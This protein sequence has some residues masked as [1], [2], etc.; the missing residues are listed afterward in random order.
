MNV[1]NGQGRCSVFSILGLS[2][3]RVG[4]ELNRVDAGYTVEHRAEETVGWGEAF[5]DDLLDEA[6]VGVG[7]GYA[8]QSVELLGALEAGQGVL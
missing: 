1:R 7:R 3:L 4:E 5:D 2:L 8:H 6:Q